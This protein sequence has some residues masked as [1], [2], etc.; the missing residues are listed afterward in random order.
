[1]TIALENR[2]HTLD[3]RTH[4]LSFN[5]EWASPQHGLWVASA[6]GE[7]LG[8]IERNDNSYVASD[9]IGKSLG[10]FDSLA[11]AQIAVDSAPQDLDESRHVF[12]LKVVLFGS[13]VCS[14]IA[15]FGMF[16]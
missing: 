8:M 9:R 10:T 11:D 5:P 6:D 1:M 12:A 15:A 13:L 14:T 16:H 4:T 2:S 7:F 3:T